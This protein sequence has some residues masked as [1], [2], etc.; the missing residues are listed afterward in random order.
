MGITLARPLLGYQSAFAP[1]VLLAI[2][3]PGTL[4][5]VV[6]LID[7]ISEVKPKW[8]FCVQIAA[9]VLLYISGFRIVS[10]PALLGGHQFTWLAGLAI[11][12]LWV[13]WITNAFNLI[14]GIDGLAA[15]SAMISTLVLFL[16]A[17]ISANPLQL[18]ITATLAGA[19]LGFLR[20]NF[21]PATIFLGDCGSLFV[22]FTLSA[23]ALNT[24]SKSPTLVAVA[25]PAIAFGLPIV[26]TSFSVVR[27][28]LRGRPLFS[29]DREHI[30]HKLLDKGL[31]QRS[32][33]LL[34][35]GVSALFGL[36]SLLLN[37]PSS[38]VVAVVLIV[39]GTV[40]FIG[41]QHLGYFELFEMRRIAARTIEQR[42]I[43]INN[44]AIRTAMHRLG[45]AGTMSEIG[46]ILQH[47]FRDNDFDEYR[48]TAGCRSALDPLHVDG[49]T[50][51][52]WSKNGQET[53]SGW[54]LTIDL[55]DS[56]GDPRGSFTVI[57][58]SDRS[59]LLIDVN[60]LISE[61]PK[62]LGDALARVGNTT[63]RTALPASAKFK[64]ATA[65]S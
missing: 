20:F 33:V 40:V 31:S 51:L 29:P 23:L 52:A 57:R 26:D 49:A 18:L 55:L 38:R 36:L 37:L 8:K 25:L 28:F 61:F 60:L 39:V 3:I 45:E 30:H 17:L 12:V 6:G 22:G 54:S 13:V 58:A 42:Q 47:A 9:G 50:V 14:D 48:L 59:S 44:L 1:T 35:Y 21:N 11:T 2:A 10:V 64:V 16:S 53:P 19:I 46:Q 32:A 56:T 62:A 43:I 15:G 7:D 65:H 27:R 24:N 41:I 63:V 4:V 34:L 5:F